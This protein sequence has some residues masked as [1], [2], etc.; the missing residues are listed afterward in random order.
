VWL[1]GGGLM[2]GLRE[3]LPYFA[4]DLGC[5]RLFVDHC[6]L[7]FSFERTTQQM[8]PGVA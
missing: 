4:G 2:R 5:P 1:M 7:S 8:K 6:G 3:Q